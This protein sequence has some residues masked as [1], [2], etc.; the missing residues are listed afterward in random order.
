V[1][2]VEVVIALDGVDRVLDDWLELLFDYL[3]DLL[4]DSLGLRVERQ[5]HVVSL[6]DTI[7][8]LSLSRRET[9]GD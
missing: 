2:R 4:S 6:R 9:A 1:F 5:I 3:P 7:I 8:P